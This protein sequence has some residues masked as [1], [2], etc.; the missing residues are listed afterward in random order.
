[1]N[2]LGQLSKE[3]IKFYAAEIVNILEYLHMNGVAHRDF[4]VN[5][6]L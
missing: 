4:K 6:F 5:Y 2:V 3:Q 1:M